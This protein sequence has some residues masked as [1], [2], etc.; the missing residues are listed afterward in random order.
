MEEI[1]YSGKALKPLKRWLLLSLSLAPLLVSAVNKASNL[2]VALP[3]LFEARFKKHL[4]S[5]FIAGES[6]SQDIFMDVEKELSSLTEAYL[7]LM[8]REDFTLFCQPLIAKSR[9]S[10]V[11]VH[12]P[13]EM[14]AQLNSAARFSALV[15]A[16]AIDTRQKNADIKGADIVATKH[17]VSPLILTNPKTLTFI[18]SSN[19]NR[20]LEPGFIAPF[21]KGSQVSSDHYR[22][23]AEPPRFKQIAPLPTLTLN[24]AGTSLLTDVADASAQTMHELPTVLIK[25]PEFYSI[26]SEESSL[27]SFDAGKHES[28]ITASRY[29]LPAHLFSVDS[30]DG[31]TAIDIFTPFAA[32]LSEQ[33]EQHFAPFSW[34]CFAKVEAPVLNEDSLASPAMHITK[35]SHSLLHVETLPFKESDRFWDM[36]AVAAQIFK[37]L[38]QPMP[39]YY[40]VAVAPT[41]EGESLSATYIYS[42]LKALELSHY[43]LQLTSGKELD[44]SLPATSNIGYKEGSALNTKDINVAG[45]HY[46]GGDEL[47]GFNA[48]VATLTVMP[49]RFASNAEF[50]LPQ[51]VVSAFGLEKGTYQAKNYQP[52]SMTD[53]LYKSGA[54]ASY[55]PVDVQLP[56]QKMVARSPSLLAGEVSEKAPLLWIA[57][58]KEVYFGTSVHDVFPLHQYEIA[59]AHTQQRLND[60]QRV[61]IK[62]ASSHFERR[63][64][65][66]KVASS[67]TK[68]ACSVYE[69][70]GYAP[71]SRNET[72]YIVAGPS[73]SVH[74]PIYLEQSGAYL[75]IPGSFALFERAPYTAPAMAALPPAKEGK[76]LEVSKTSKAPAID[77][78]ALLSQP[79][80][81]YSMPPLLAYEESAG[82][83]VQTPLPR[84]P[85]LVVP[86]GT[87]L[88]FNSSM[89][90]ML[91]E[92]EAK[93]Y[94]QP[95]HVAFMKLS[96]NSASGLPPVTPLY[97][98]GREGQTY[99]PFLYEDLFI[100]G[101]REVLHLVQSKGLT[102][103]RQSAL[104]VYSPE[105]LTA[106]NF[107]H[108]NS[109]SVYVPPETLGDRISVAWLQPGKMKQEELL[110]VDTGASISSPEFVWHLGSTRLSSYHSEADQLIAAYKR[111]IAK[112]FPLS[113]PGF[114]FHED[115]LVLANQYISNMNFRQE[116]LIS[117]MQD[118]LAYEHIH[119]NDS[120][121][122][123]VQY[124]YNDQ[125]QLYEFEIALTPKVRA[126]HP[127]TPQNFIFIIDNSADVNSQRFAGF[128]KGITKSL[129]YI[130]PSD[131]IALIHAGKDFTAPFNEPALASGETKSYLSRFVNGLKYSGYY[132]RKTLPNMIEHAS[133][134]FV[135][136]RENV[137]IVLSESR[138]FNNVRSLQHFMRNFS[139][140]QNHDFAVYAAT[141]RSNQGLE[142]A[143]LVT[144][145]HQGSFCNSPSVASFPRNLALMVK[146]ACHTISSHLEISLD[147]ASSDNVTL[148]P[149]MLSST[150]FSDEPF[151]LYGAAKDLTAFAID[152][153]AHSRDALLS[154]PL[155]IDL[156]SAK[157]N[158][159]A[160]MYQTLEKQKALSFLHTAYYSDDEIFLECFDSMVKNG[161]LT[162]T[163]PLV[164]R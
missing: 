69:E 8:G 94:S 65:D 118:Q 157:E 111:E 131:S 25:R 92:S 14:R 117:Y 113:T 138:A 107:S 135:R 87:R 5:S 19:L 148:Y 145:L 101:Q 26:K 48:E 128:K 93:H 10:A 81:S 132:S 137:V 75:S 104:L 96:P 136:G 103:S 28:F 3:H 38:S 141:C 32:L 11:G 27:P 79:T 56:L 50:A 85:A 63:N 115:N 90:P 164:F 13:R 97:R 42:P 45:A 86:A 102:S 89:A 98:M 54:S 134:F 68:W 80:T 124:A 114:F 61:G 9:L 91:V 146:H 162:T 4:N 15:D 41:K 121:K 18:F 143:K 112:N 99:E 66:L 147:G 84:P 76:R 43:S 154:L 122:C 73:D 62:Q 7:K 52:L 82:R 88:S 33:T 151:K 153:K 129:A 140:E 46:R 158:S 21:V 40:V 105:L 120:Y 142:G 58:P 23:A 110:Y 130:D 139:E 116:R 60:S 74:V 20:S 34:V 12:L 95:L 156:A 59:Q 161:S 49:M 16:L 2:D 67:S 108:Q 150:L 72:P 119:L 123:D 126:N 29:Q 106:Q 155:Y 109:H 37:G 39:Y 47:P 70:G 6:Q 100:K 163:S 160:L 30:V 24:S 149:S 31:A 36:P 133:E 77:I 125:T 57:T 64:V 22:L 83:S 51:V 1:G 44:L 152:I 17:L 35:Q 144:Q 78:D 71:H 53:L 159:D 127:K 55:S